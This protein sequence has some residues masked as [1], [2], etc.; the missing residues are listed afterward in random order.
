MHKFEYVIV[1]ILFMLL[2]SLSLR[3]GRQIGLILYF[4]VARILRYRRS[5]ILENL[6][7]VY[8]ETL[9]MDKGHLL[10]EI[11]KNFVFLW[12]EYLQAD[13]RKRNE[14][15]QS[16]RFHNLELVDK[17][18]KKG[19]GLI[20]VTGHMGNFEWFAYVM[21]MMG[22]SIAGVAKRQSNPYINEMIFKSRT[23]FG[24]EVIYTKTA[25]KDGLKTLLENKILGLVAD[26]DAKNRGIFVDFLG[27]PSSTAVGPAVFHL[28]SGAPIMFCT[29][30]R[31]DYA[32]FDVYFEAPLK[33]FEGPV[34]DDKVREITEL[35]VAALERWVHQ[36]PEQWFWT[37]RRW[38]TRAA[39]INQNGK[40]V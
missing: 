4:I 27:V 16:C 7:R 25:M 40:P 20:L 14:M 24:T 39:D 28:R 18:L 3:T 17:E 26:Q 22:Y 15:A 1:K 6:Y 10:K 5:V 35:H 13:F 36:N 21:A 37:H 31:R 11:Y 30:V 38:K 29:S 9:P 19:K 12:M 33:S 34:N 8:G 2:N 32:D 23:K